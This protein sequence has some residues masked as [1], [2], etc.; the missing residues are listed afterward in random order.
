MCSFEERRALGWGITSYRPV[1][2]DCRSFPTTLATPFPTQITRSGYAEVTNCFVYDSHDLPEDLGPSL[3]RNF[4]PTPIDRN[5]AGIHEPVS[6]CLQ[7][8]Q[9]MDLIL[10]PLWEGRPSLDRPEVFE[11]L[12]AV[13]AGVEDFPELRGAVA[14]RMM[15]IIR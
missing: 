1:K 15:R 7:V 6:F 11:V 2:R 12:Y 3:V 14:R 8:L 10:Q 13:V 4:Y 5:N 9:Q